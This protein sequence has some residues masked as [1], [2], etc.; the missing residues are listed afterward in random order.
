MKKKD[1]IQKWLNHNLNAAEL[2]AFK[3]LDAYSSLQKIQD[4]SQHYKAPQYNSE[5]AFK[6]LKQALPTATEKRFPRYW[7]AI[8]AVVV[9]AISVSLSVF[10][11]DIVTHTSMASVQENITLPDASTATLLPNSEIAFSEDT[12]SKDRAISL[13]GAAYFDVKK[14]SSFTVQSTQ[15]KV[16]V[17][18]TQFSV[19]DWGDFFE[20]TCFEGSVRVEGYGKTSILK[21]GMSFR[22]LEDTVTIVPADNEPVLWS[23]AHTTFNSVPVSAV[24]DFIESNYSVTFKNKTELKG[25]FTGKVSHDNLNETLN[26]VT[27]PFNVS[28]E[29][30]NQ[31][32]ILKSE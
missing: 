27:I 13:K 21:P 11:T 3:E 24:L 16:T 32:V 30:R 17:L 1:L 31:I 15:G 12:W 8:A 10:K 28:F 19:K 4:A 22:A 5:E 23:S 29:I 26:V 20:V 25:M 9:I 14:G 6:N 18:G 2:K 7:V